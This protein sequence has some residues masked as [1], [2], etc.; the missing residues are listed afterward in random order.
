MA[1]V[2]DVAEYILERQGQM[3]AMKLQKLCYYSQAWHLV[4]DEEPLFDDDFQAW[5]NGPVSRRL[6]DK[7]RR[8]YSVSAGMVDGDPTVL[9]INQ[10]ESIDIVLKSYAHMRAFELSEMTHREAPWREARG[11]LPP[12]MGSNAVIDKATMQEFYEGLLGSARA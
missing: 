7:H 8:L 9:T 12:G 2:L 6:Y 11:E 4:W 3:S 1:S 5:A 10:R